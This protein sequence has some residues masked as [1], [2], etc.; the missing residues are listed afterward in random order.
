MTA[1]ANDQDLSE[2]KLVE[3]VEGKAYQLHY[4]HGG[5]AGEAKHRMVAQ[6]GPRRPIGRI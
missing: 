6:V 1:L 3:T 4:P 5:I 2:P